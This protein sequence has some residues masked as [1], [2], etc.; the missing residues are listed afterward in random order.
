[1]PDYSTSNR[2]GVNQTTIRFSLDDTNPLSAEWLLGYFNEALACGSRFDSGQTVQ[3]GWMI[4]KLHKANDGALELWEPDFD[5]FPIRWINGVN[6]TMRHLL[7]QRAICEEL[8]FEPDFPSLQHSGIV[9]PG[10]ASSE[11]FTL[12]REGPEGVHSGWFLM[13]YGYQGHQAEHQSLYQLVLWN[14]CIVP[15]L[16]LPPG[17]TVH[18]HSGGYEVLYCKN[19]LTSCE[20]KL[21]RRLVDTTPV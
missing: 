6:I 21:L 19:K 13:E 17:S 1:M 20:N 9:S 2:D 16:A 8:K 7:L 11:D 3:I 12:S 18:R 10:F 4:C 15:F 14:S 5:S